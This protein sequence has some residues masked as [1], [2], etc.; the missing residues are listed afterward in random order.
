MPDEN[1]SWIDCECVVVEPVDA[2]AVYTN[3]KGNIVIRQQS[4]MGDDDPIVVV[5]R[6]RVADIIAALKREA[7]AA[8]PASEGVGA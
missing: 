5:P 4:A 7:D 2:I 8:P 1:F 6:S 3:L